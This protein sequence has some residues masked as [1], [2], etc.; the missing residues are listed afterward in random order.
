MEYCVNALFILDKNVKNFIY[1][2]IVKY[3][4]FVYQYTH[5]H[6]FKHTE[7][8]TYVWMNFYI[9]NKTATYSS[10]LCFTRE[11]F[12]EHRNRFYEA[13]KANCFLVNTTSECDPKDRKSTFR[14]ENSSIQRLRLFKLTLYRFRFEIPVWIRT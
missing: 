2:H 3:N 8:H 12:C 4:L 6:T 1:T 13:A 5:T 7:P 11:Y 14:S 10:N 9:F